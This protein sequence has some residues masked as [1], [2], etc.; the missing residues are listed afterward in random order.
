MGINEVTRAVF[1]D[2]DGIINKSVV[3]DGRPFPPASVAELELTDGIEDVLSVL[4]KRGFLLI[5]VT[6]QPDV[7]R[8]MVPVSQVE[9]IHAHLKSRLGLDGIYV[10]YHDDADGCLC[11]K[12]KPGLLLQAAADFEIDLE[13]SYMVGDRWR[14]I[15][16]GVSA[17]CTTIFVDYRYS[18]SLN[19]R[20]DFTVPQ[21]PAILAH[22]N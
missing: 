4:R 10:C 7:A 20:P 6:N 2:R 17:R 16:A 21:P 13:K 22:I 1:L 18:E 11:R 19:R 15:D 12:P 8:R 3:R 5:V 14:D 9:S